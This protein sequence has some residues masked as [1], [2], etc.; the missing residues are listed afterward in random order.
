MLTS[1]AVKLMYATD[2]SYIMYNMIGIAIIIYTLFTP[3]VSTFMTLEYILL[4][5]T[6]FL[7]FLY[8]VVPLYYTIAGYIKIHFFLSILAS[9]GVVIYDQINNIYYATLLLLVI[10]TAI[11]YGVYY[12]LS[13]MRKTPESRI[14]SVRKI[15]DGERIL[16]ILERQKSY[17]K[18]Y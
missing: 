2:I 7:A 6:A 10:M 8:F 11:L 16:P 9:V 5:S 13:H 15:L 12:I 18:T 1:Y 4:F 17:K 14:L 3:G